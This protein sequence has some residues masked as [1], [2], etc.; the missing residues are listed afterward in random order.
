[1][2]LSMSLTGIPCRK[3]NESWFLDHIHWRPHD[4]ARD[5]RFRRVELVGG[6]AD[7]V[8][9]LTMDEALALCFIARV[10]PGGGPSE[11]NEE[12]HRVLL[13]H[14]GS[15]QFVLARIYEW[16]GACG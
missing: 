14:K 2:A 7:F 1:M 15:T 5:P 10:R 9:V 6:Y 16:E 8:A 11:P 13:S 4:L 12:V 3:S